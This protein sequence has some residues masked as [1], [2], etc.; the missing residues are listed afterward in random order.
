MAEYLRRRWEPRF[1]GLT[2]RD[3]GGCSYDAY[4]PDPLDG[5]GGLVGVES[6]EASEAGYRKLLS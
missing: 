5:I 6:F 4:L 1:E 2:R 3:R